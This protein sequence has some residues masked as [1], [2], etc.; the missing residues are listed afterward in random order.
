MQ[1]EHPVGQLSQVPPLS[2]NPAEQVT[3]VLT[4]HWFVALLNTNPVLHEVHS[5]V[6]GPKQVKQ[7]EWHGVQTGGF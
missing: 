5:V 4:S 6:L 2:Q 7:S 1:S 3:V